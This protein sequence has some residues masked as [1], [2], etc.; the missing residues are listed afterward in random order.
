M[1]RI[2]VLFIL[3]LC[4]LQVAFT[5]QPHPS[6]ELDWAKGFAKTITTTYPD[7]IVVKKFAQHMLQDKEG[8]DPS[9]RTAVWNYEEAVVLKGMLRLWEQSGDQS[10]FN[11]TRKII[12]H[13][14]GAD[15]S[16]RTYQPLEY[17][18]DQL[19]GGIILLELYRKTG[20]QKY[21]VAMDHL[22]EQ[23]QWQP[24]TK[25]GGFWH[26]YKYPYQMWLDGAYML[27]YFYASYAKAFDKE[28]FTDIAHQLIWMEN[29]M[30]DPGTGLLYHGWD[31][32]RKQGWA[33]PVTGRSPEVW[34]RAMGWYAMAL[35][36]ILDLFPPKHLQRKELIRI[37]SDMMQA[38]ANYQDAAS[39]VWYQ[40]PNKGSRPGNYLEASGSTMFTYALVKGLN[41]GYLPATL[42]PVLNKAYKGLINTFITVDENG[43]PHIHHSCSGA[44][45]GGIP[46][47]PGT[48][49]YYVNEPQRSDDLKTIGPLISLFLEMEKYLKKSN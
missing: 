44:G 37:L 3:M 47:R 32:S 22:W 30:K 40:I 23:I 16:I 6:G 9:K 31:E 46:Y 28:V 43:L 27:D 17:N 11:F 4:L 5:Q 21:K 41:K 33:D 20:E 10:L 13:F 39:G 18:S 49:S 48:Y 26:K 35:V 34:N 42:K 15:G 12:D 14:I 7:S 25:E 38:V 24:R 19:T 8:S 2:I 45:L 36:D 29:H 1:K